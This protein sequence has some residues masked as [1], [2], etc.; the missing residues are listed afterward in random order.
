MRDFLQLSTEVRTELNRLHHNIS[1]SGGKKDKREFDSEEKTKI[2][3]LKSALKNTTENEGNRN[4]DFNYLTFNNNDGTEIYNVQLSFPKDSL[5]SSSDHLNENSKVAFIQTVKQL[6]TQKE[7]E[8]NSP[9]LYN[10][11]EEEEEESNQEE[12][13]GK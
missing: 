8:E 3:C 2:S 12:D 7:N 9:K 6:H 5:H 4:D 1:R 10:S 13:H 11:E